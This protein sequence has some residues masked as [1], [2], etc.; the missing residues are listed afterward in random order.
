LDDKVRVIGTTENG[1]YGR[2]KAREVHTKLRE[3][4]AG[5]PVPRE[6]VFMDRAALGIGSVCIRLQSE[7]NWYQLFNELIEGFDVKNLKQA[8]AKLLPEYGL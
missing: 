1:V 7:L 6:F 8:Q 3:L 5:V 4:R 2:E